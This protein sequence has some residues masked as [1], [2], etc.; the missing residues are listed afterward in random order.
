MTKWKQKEVC[1]NFKKLI[2]LATGILIFLLLVHKIILGAGLST[3]FGE[4]RLSNLK[5]GQTYGMRE[6]VNFPLQ[7]VNT[8]DFA[9]ELKIDVLVPK[10]SEA[11][12]GYEPIPDASWIEMEKDSFIL[13]PGQT[14]IS[15]VLIKIPDDEKY[16]GKGFEVNLWSHTVGKGKMIAVGLNSRLLFSIA[17]E[18][19]TAEEISKKKKRKLV[20]NVNFSL[21]PHRFVL[22][23]VEVGKK[24]NIEKMFNEV[25]K[26]VNPNNEKLTIKL[27]S[28]SLRE[29][30]LT[31]DA[32]FTACPDPSFLSFS[33]KK[34]T[35]KGNSIKL[36][37]MHLNFPDR[38]E[39]KGK[40]YLF[41]ISAR[42]EGQEVPVEVFARVYVTTKE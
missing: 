40:K 15:D 26:V 4:V 30:E 41:I 12:E 2:Y 23:N 19:A 20:G 25:L 29:A 14:A 10:S 22:Q 37:K 38:N 31:P 34:F 21:V 13:E 9:V 33:D 39:Y 35:V 17:R 3:K 6:L 36:V 18:R 27:Y 11:K 5:I 8:S 16:F 32:G 1:V 28:M 7:V 42:I 24:V